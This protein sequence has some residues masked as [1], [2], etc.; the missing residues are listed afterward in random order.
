MSKREPVT[1][2]RMLAVLRYV[3]EH[4]GCTNRE[5]AYAV[6]PNGLHAY[7]D[8]IVSRCA[9]HGLIRDVRADGARAYAWEL[10]AEGRIELEADKVRVKDIA[11]L[12]DEAV[13]AGDAAQAQLCEKA[14][15]GA[16]DGPNWQACAR[17]IAAAR[18][19]P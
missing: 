5:V 6:G 7:G 11:V 4:P 2:L 17:V 13:R 16:V 18:L 8:R 3:A 10:T 14:I 9:R 15:N 12:R 19:A 1:G